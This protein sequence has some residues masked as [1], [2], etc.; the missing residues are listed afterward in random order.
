VKIVRS[1]VED[2]NEMIIVVKIFKRIV[3]EIWSLSIVIPFLLIVF[4]FIL[5]YSQINPSGTSVRLMFYFLPI[6]FVMWIYRYGDYNEF[7]MNVRRVMV[8][9]I[10]AVLTLF[11]NDPMTK[12]FD[13]Q[14]TNIYFSQFFNEFSVLAFLALDRVGKVLIEIFS[15]AKCTEKVEKTG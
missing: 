4:M 5:F 12:L 8:Y 2:L 13:V 9:V 15:R 3:F 6:F 1:W 14:S 10:V 11:N 7:K